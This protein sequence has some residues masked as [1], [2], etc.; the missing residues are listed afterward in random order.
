MATDLANL[1]TRRTAICVELAALSSTAAG[2]K[3][4]VSAGGI[5]IEHVAYKKSLY[6]ELASIDKA[7]LSID[8]PYEIESEMVP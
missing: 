6:E 3:P 8:G 5:K 2:G 4:D 7:I 1:Q